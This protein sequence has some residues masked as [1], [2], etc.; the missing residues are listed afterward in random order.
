MR[1]HDEIGSRHPAAIAD[2]PFDE[3]RRDRER[4]IRND[5]ERAARQAKIGRVGSNDRHLP[6]VKPLRE[7]SRPLRVQLER[8]DA[9]SRF[10]ECGRQ[11]AS[12]S[13]DVE[14][15]VTRSDT[16][17]CNDAAHFATIELMPPPPGS[18]D[19]GHGGP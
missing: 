12:S 2:E 10:H 16:S 9:C 3:R 7:Q 13:A 15:Q 8:D 18:A 1:R 5:L 11:R 6:T 17:V 14:Y 4:W 19:R